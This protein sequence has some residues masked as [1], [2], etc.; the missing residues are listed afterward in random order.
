MVNVRD[1]MSK[2]PNHLSLLLIVGF[3]A[4]ALAGCDVAQVSTCINDGVCTLDEQLAN[5][6]SDCPVIDLDNS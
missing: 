5:S 3:V 4:I 6:C 2:I 1:Y